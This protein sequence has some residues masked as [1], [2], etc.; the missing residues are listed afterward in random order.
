MCFSFGVG[1]CCGTSS[2]PYS[3]WLRWSSVTWW[4]WL[5]CLTTPGSSWEWLQAPPLATTSLTHCSM[6]DS[7]T[8]G[9]SVPRRMP[10]PEWGPFRTDLQGPGLVYQGLEITPVIFIPLNPILPQISTHAGYLYN[11]LSAVFCSFYFYKRIALGKKMQ[12]C[13]WTIFNDCVEK[14]LD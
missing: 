3:T 1:G 8:W 7:S 12:G 14:T 6:Q 9:S 4:C 13:I 5:L 10:K 11:F 2:R